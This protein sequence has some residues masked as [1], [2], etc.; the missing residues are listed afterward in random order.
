FTTH[1]G[2]D[3][4]HHRDLV[5]LAHV[6]QQ[7]MV[8]FLPILSAI[9][10]QLAGLARAEADPGPLAELAERTADW[11]SAEGPVDMQ[12]G[13]RLLSELAA[14]EAR[15]RRNWT[16]FLRGALAE[17][18][19]ELVN[20]WLD[21]SALQAAIAGGGHDQGRVTQLLR[22]AAPY[23]PQ[24][25]YLTAAIAGL[26]AATTVLLFAAF[27]IATGWSYGAAGMQVAGVF[28]CILASIDNPVPALRKFLIYMLWA[29]FAGF[30]YNYLVFPHFTQFSSIV[31]ALGLYLI[32]AGIL[33]TRP[34]TMLVGLTLCV[35]L[36]YNLTLQSRLSLDFQAYLENNISF[37]LAMVCAILCTSMIR[38]IGAEA[39]AR[40]VLQQAWRRIASIAASPRPA[41]PL[42]LIQEL[43]DAFGLATPRLAQIPTSA[44]ALASDLIRDLRVGLNVLS[45]HD[46]RTTLPAA[47]RQPLDHVL[48][49][50]ARYYS[51]LAHGRSAETAP[52]LAAVDACLDGRLP[53][54]SSRLSHRITTSLAGLRMGINPE[55]APPKLAVT[56]QDHAA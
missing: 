34:D 23:R 53:T 22:T 54:P 51:D 44:G 49:L 17:R 27:W 7:R 50:T 26:A 32:P 9:R 12:E 33:M 52:L 8:A 18:L 11:L 25:D 19:I 15:P 46:A 30:V 28:C 3:T 20:S 35:N 47:A 16:D 13:G 37:V 40:R 42:A 39:A 2:Y 31:A 14:I 10:D 6:L 5:G 21:C 24:R 1:V 4:S 36:P 29:A 56:Q 41:A 48:A 38:S 55:A 45:L 43:T